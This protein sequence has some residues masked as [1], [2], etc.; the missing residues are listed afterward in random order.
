M[1]AVSA[2]SSVASR[3]GIALCVLSACAFGAMAVFAKQA[4][5]SG[6]NVVTL[7]A[8]RFVLAAALFWALA[9]AR[10]ARLPGRRVVVGALAL[11][12]FGYAAQ[13]GLYF[14]ALTRIDA[15]LAS[16]LTY[17]YPV[18]VFGAALAMGRE[19][20]SGRRLG[21]LALASCGTLLVLL[22]GSI[23]AVDE[24]GV[25]MALGCAVVYAGYILVSDRMVGAVDPFVLAALVTTGAA[26]SMVVVGGGTGSLDAGFAGAG[27]LWIAALAAATV[28]GISAFLTGMRE[29]GP[30]TA[31]I[32]ST[33]EPA[34]TVGLATSI[35]GEA[36][37]S[38]QL[39]GGVLVLGAVVIL[40]LRA[41]RVRDSVDRD[42][43][44]DLAAVV[45]PARALA[46]EPA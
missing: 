8:V 17:I 18:L 5:A 35:Y 4:Y 20:L 46:H 34:V 30:G 45:T 16:L 24:A 9:V 36:L 27:W 39:A 2:P 37:G 31:S 25:A 14:G 28:V 42:A 44:A 15:S 11:G 23:G 7:L 40:Q 29:V 22:G 1:T 26:A 33:V 43:A 32:V 21:A 41:A 38:S 6:V 13:G 12:A 19:H 3:R 10:G